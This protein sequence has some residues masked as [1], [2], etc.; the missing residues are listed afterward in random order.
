MS[1]ILTAAFQR[2][3]RMAQGLDGGVVMLGARTSKW[4]KAR[5]GEFLDF[6][7]SASIE[8]GLSL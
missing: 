6:I 4:D 3:T 5:M 7:Q 8:H 2:E 1:N